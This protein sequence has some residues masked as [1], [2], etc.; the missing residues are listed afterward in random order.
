MFLKILTFSCLIS[1]SSFTFSQKLI[2]GKILDLKSRRPVEKVDITI[3]KGT[4]VTT[5]NAHG[6]F[7]L[8]VQKEDSLLIT[9]RDYKTGLIAIPEANVFSIL[10]EP[11]DNYPIY[12][13]GSGSLYDYLQQNL[14]YP[15]GALTKELEGIILIELI[16]DSNGQIADCRCLH[17]IGGKCGKSAIAVFHAIPGEWSKSEESNSFIFPVVYS[18]G[19][20][21]KSFEI[22][23]IELPFSKLMDAVHILSYIN[24]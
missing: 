15:Q 19:I 14:K 20:Q 8:T 21:P 24:K 22:P 1:T 7:Q 12:I 10:M 9:H 5:S 6:F 16:I 3:F 17:D 18:L 11:H 2:T 4:E 13:N 23:N